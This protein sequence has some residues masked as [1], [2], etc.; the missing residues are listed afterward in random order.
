MEKDISLDPMNVSFFGM[1]TI[2]PR[3]D[4]IPNL[5]Q[6]LWFRRRPKR[7]T[8]ALKFNPP[9]ITAS[10]RLIGLRVFTVS[11]ILPLSVTPRTVVIVFL[12]IPSTFLFLASHQTAPADRASSA[13]TCRS[14]A[15]DDAQYPR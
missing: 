14:N 10:A 13:R 3:P 5:V 8:L 15:R 12:E 4:R 11:I 2:M 7:P 6:Q 9:S 1:V